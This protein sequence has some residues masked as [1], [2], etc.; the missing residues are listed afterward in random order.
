MVVVQIQGLENVQKLFTK[1]PK[2]I[3]KNIGEDGQKEIMLSAQRKIK[4]RYNILG[5]GKGP[6]STGF[7]RKSIRFIKTKT[8]YDLFGA[9][10]IALLDNRIRSHWVSMDIVEAHRANPGS[11]MF[12]KAPGTFLFNRPPVFWTYKGPVVA[13]SIM[14]LKRELPRIME[15]Q[16][17]KAMQ[18][19]QS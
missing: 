10:Y 7:G 12:Q 19:A 11:T 1:L 13:P 6:L 9:A 3:Q 4:Y 2:S 8:G 17:N 18:M 5:Y 14:K 16:L 15:K